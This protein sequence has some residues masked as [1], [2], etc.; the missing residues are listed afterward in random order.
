MIVLHGVD[1][2]IGAVDAKVA[3]M[4]AA[5]RAATAKALHLIE[6]RAKQKLGLKS[7]RRGTPTPA[8][9]GEP[10]A[11]V[12]GNLRR[13]I[14]VTGPEPLTPNSWR[15]RVGPTAVYGRVQELGGVTGRGVL[16]ARP[17]LEPAYDEL[18]PEIAALFRAAWTKAI[19]S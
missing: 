1:R 14:A 17:Y 9:P 16:P 8:G 13:S 6:R 10:P 4:R 18:K 19:L 11:L 7:H 15:G 2:F 3:H 5:T 12:T